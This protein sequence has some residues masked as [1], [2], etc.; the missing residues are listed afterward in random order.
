VNGVSKE[1]KISCCTLS[2]HVDKKVKQPGIVNLGRHVQVLPPHTE[3]ESHDHTKCMER[4]M[5]YKL[6]HPFNK[7]TNCAGKNWMS[8]F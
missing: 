6:K 4:S 7:V 3:Q 2:R 8:G 1:Y 5:Q